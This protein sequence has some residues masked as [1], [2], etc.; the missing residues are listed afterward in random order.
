VNA[1]TERTNAALSY[2][3]IRCGYDLKGLD[4]SGTCPECGTPISDSIRS[5]RLVFANPA[6]V[7]RLRSG[8]LTLLLTLV[9]GAVILVLS[10]LSGILMIL[11]GPFWLLLPLVVLLHLAGW[12]VFASPEPHA[13]ARQGEPKRKKLRSVSVV[14]FLGL[15]L[16]VGLPALRYQSLM[17]IPSVTIFIVTLV[18][19]A[20]SITTATRYVEVIADRLENK[21]IRV[22]ARDVRFLTAAIILVVLSAVACLTL[23]IGADADIILGVTALVLGA[24]L[25]FVYFLML[26]MLVA[27]LDRVGTAIE[28]RG[29]G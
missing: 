26:A 24:V 12:W 9:T 29:R 4:A 14:S 19:G 5:D 6:F 2:P 17:F 23:G 3:C 22:R 18:F 15:L 25:V 20:M 11:A 28:A 27:A 16:F 8:A 1:S 7:R 10:I 13:P 21:R